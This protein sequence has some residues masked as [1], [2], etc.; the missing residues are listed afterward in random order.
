MRYQVSGADGSRVP[1]PALRV[2]VEDPLVADVAA[3]P[4]TPFDVTVCSGPDDEHE[5]CPLV[6]RGTC[7]LG[8][9][10]V[11][12]S[13]LDGPWERAVR[14]AWAETPTPYVDSAAAPSDPAA[15]L[16]HH[17]G[18]AIQRLAVPPAR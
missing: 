4:G 2:L 15:R 8:P 1:L 5:T 16:T 10:D 14:A 17:L 12:V 6:M 18:A 9:F 7:P 11:V 3:P 13:A